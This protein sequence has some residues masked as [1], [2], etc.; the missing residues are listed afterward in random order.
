MDCSLPGFSVHGILHSRILEWTAVSYFRGSSWLR[1]QT[2]ASFSLSEWK[3]L[4][5]VDS[6]QPHGLKPARLLCPWNSLDQ[7]TGVSNHFLLQEIF[8][9]QGS[10]PGLLHFRRILYCL[11]HQGSPE[12]LYDPV[13]QPQII[14]PEKTITQKDTCIIMF[15]AALFNSPDVDTT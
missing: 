12:L 4:S 5:H 8:P 13:I 3:S 2:Q 6:L 15:I 1:D 14:C 11:G 7:N 9:T 10:N